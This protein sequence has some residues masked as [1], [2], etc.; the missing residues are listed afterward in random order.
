MR[1]QNLDAAACAFID[2]A[3]FAERM[4]GTIW[5]ASHGGVGSAR[6]YETL[7]L[8]Y[9]EIQVRDRPLRGVVSHLPT[10]FRAG[11]SKCIYLFG[12][13]IDAVISQLRRGHFDNP[14]KLRNNTLYPPV[15]MPDDLLS[16]HDSDPFGINRQ[17]ANFCTAMVDYPILLIKRSAL[18]DQIGMLG[19]FAERQQAVEWIEETRKTSRSAISAEALAHIGRAYGFTERIMAQMP[20]VCLRLPVWLTGYRYRPD[21]G[22][23]LDYQPILGSED[24]ARAFL[25]RSQGSAPDADRIR[26]KHA[27]EW[28][29]AKGERQCIVNVRHDIVDTGF[30]SIGYLLMI[31]CAN[32]DAK[33]ITHPD[34]LE[35][36]VY[37]GAEDPRYF[38]RRDELGVIFNALCSDG[39]R[40]MFIYFE[41][42]AQC[43]K[44]QV[45]GFPLRKTEKNWTVLVIADTI[46]IVYSFNPT[47]VFRLDDDKTGMCSVVSQNGFVLTNEHEPLFPFGGSSLQLWSWPHFVG[48]VHTPRPHYRPALIVFDAQEMRVTAIGKPFSVPKPARAVASRGLEVEYPYHLEVD[49]G[50]CEMWIEC[51]DHCPTRYRFEFMR[52]CEIVSTLIALK[53]VFCGPILEPAT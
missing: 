33:K 51:Q 9:P 10:P 24:A 38:R 45:P 25:C 16:M 53:P 18:A 1:Y 2:E 11:P 3:E 27:Y 31:N 20:E 28:E 30:G 43:I 48:L 47:I 17:F 8:N 36:R 15:H 49:K 6:L 29:N 39:S 12:D 22:D 52:F 5:L 35:D 4:R 21:P 34:I 46:Y 14:R 19:E 41:R 26:L 50:K 7:G 37:S 32:R 44:L 42:L 13:P 23:V 40:R